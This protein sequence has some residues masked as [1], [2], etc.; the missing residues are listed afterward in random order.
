MP[1]AESPLP[2]A[3]RVGGKVVLGFHVY[4]YHGLEDFGRAE[5]I[6]GPP[7]SSAHFGVQRTLKDCVE[8]VCCSVFGD[9]V[10]LLISLEVGFDAPLDERLLDGKREGGIEAFTRF[11]HRG[12]KF[13]V[14]FSPNLGAMEVECAG[15]RAWRGL[16]PLHWYSIGPQACCFSFCFNLT[17]LD[18]SI[19]RTNGG[20]RPPAVLDR[21]ER[22][23]N[24]G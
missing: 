16:A 9:A 21:Q 10:P 1:V 18:R 12:K 11:G 3:F 22:K 5:L 24:E 8:A 17:L 7:G 19:E 14:T 20:C 13:T 15:E 4:E 23:M 2:A 6:L